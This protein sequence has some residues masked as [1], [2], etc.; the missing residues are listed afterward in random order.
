[1]QK[2]EAVT[3]VTAVL[4]WLEHGAMWSVEPTRNPQ[5]V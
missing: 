5:N 3:S 1:M 4:E 2:A